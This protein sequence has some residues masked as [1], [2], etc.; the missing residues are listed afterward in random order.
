VPVDVKVRDRIYFQ[1]KYFQPLVN[2]LKAMEGAKYDHTPGIGRSWS[3]P[4]TERNEYALAF[5]EGKD[6]RQPYLSKSPYFE[7]NDDDLE[8]FTH[9]RKIAEFILAFKRVLIAGEMGIGKTLPVLIAILNIGG[10]VLVVAP[11]SAQAEWKRQLVKFKL[12]W[13]RPY[14]LFSTYESLKKVKIRPDILVFDES[15]KIKNPLAQRS[16]VAREFADYIR[17][18]DGYLI[19]L[20][21]SPAPKDPT[22]YWNQIE[23]IQ[24]GWIREGSPRKL[25]LRLGEWTKETTPDGY[26][27]CLIKYL[28]E[29]IFPLI[30]SIRL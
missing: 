27:I 18:V 30:L 25:G 2:E 28:I 26:L 5:L 20:S 15:V 1:F 22:D 9:Q 10:S 23:V 8:L 14:L 7:F 16:R 24:P 12:E 4:I 21:G 17:K 19:L 13:L 11:K 6:P 3:I 29:S